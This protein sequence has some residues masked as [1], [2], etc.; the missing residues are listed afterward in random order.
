MSR[1][2]I[3]KRKKLAFKLTWISAISLMICG[4][5][6]WSIAR[7]GGP[8][9]L[10]AIIPL[11]IVGGVHLFTGPAA[12][13]QSY[14]IHRHHKCL[15]VYL[16]FVFFLFV[17]CYLFPPDIFTYV[18]IFALLTIVPILFSMFIALFKTHE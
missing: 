15:Y 9:A 7:E 5:W 8:E 17:T 18:I 10:G 4:S 13:Y 2:E 16:Y 14:K 3:Q 11:L 12:I 6:A 1:R